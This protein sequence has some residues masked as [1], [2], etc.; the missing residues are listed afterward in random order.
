LQC[1][2]LRG[3]C[4]S[5]LQ[6]RLVPANDYVLSAELFQDGQ[7]FQFREQIFIDQRPR[8][9]DFANAKSTLTEAEVFAKYAAA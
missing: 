5:H 7:E 4:G 1:K 2:C 9:Y 3:M 8:S 6:Y